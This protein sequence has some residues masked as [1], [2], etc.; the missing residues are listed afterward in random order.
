V[1]EPL[2]EP[3]EFDLS[4]L[5]RPESTSNK[6]SKESVVPVYS[7]TQTSYRYI[8]RSAARIQPRGL[9]SKLASTSPSPSIT[10][11]V[12]DPKSLHGE[13]REPSVAGYLITAGGDSGSHDDLD[14]DLDHD[15]DHDGD[16]DGD[17]D[18]DSRGGD[19]HEHQSFLNTPSTSGK[20]KRNV[21]TPQSSGVTHG[22][23]ATGLTPSA[24]MQ[25]P[26]VD[27]GSDQKKLS[28]QMDSASGTPTS[29]SESRFLVAPKPI[30]FPIKPNSP[31][32]PHTSPPKPTQRAVSS[33]VRAPILTTKDYDCHPSLPE[34]QQMSDDELAAVENFVI[35]RPSIGQIKWEGKTD[36]RDLNLDDLV[37]IENK[38]ISVYDGLDESEK[39]PRGEKLNKRAVVTLYQISPKTITSAAIEKFE[40]KLRKSCIKN[41]SEFL[42]YDI[43][44][45]EWMFRVSHF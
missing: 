18:D 1:T 38:M 28:L 26:L 30:K 20:S 13:R 8:P 3:L 36:L 39:P 40:K 31:H 43:E 22:G 23:E 27:T 44:L 11:T 4:G 33:N 42:H 45:Q 17:G 19:K 12:L 41:D 9:Q 2:P 35:F 14:H 6:S 7:K 37:V 16:G 10:S 24:P 5:Q 25:S 21:E 32:S 34:L 29:S 15:H